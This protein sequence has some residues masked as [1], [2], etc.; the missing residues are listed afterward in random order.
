MT[1]GSFEAM[2]L[3]HR[4]VLL[5]SMVILA[6]ITACGGNNTAGTSSNGN[7]I[8]SPDSRDQQNT[9]QISETEETEP[10][11]TELVVSDTEATITGSVES[12]A[13]LL[14]EPLS[15]VD[16]HLAKVY[17]DNDQVR[18]TFLIDEATSPVTRTDSS[19]IF[20]FTNVTA[21]DYV[22]VVGDLYAKNVIISNP[23]GTARI[24]TAEPGR[25]LD[26]GVIEVNLDLAPLPVPVESA[27]PPQPYPAP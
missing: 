17:W 1:H 10:T 7:G 20:V 4:F 12:T 13:G 27:Y 3:Q 23:D 9:P 18:G 15:D 22:I 11:K 21:R 5:L 2:R 26:V 19:G 24:Y 6:L 25:I 8:A 16:V 14:N